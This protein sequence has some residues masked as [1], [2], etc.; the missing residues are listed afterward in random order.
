[1]EKGLI[2]FKVE[3]IL[4]YDVTASYSVVASSPREAAERATHLAVRPRRTG[5]FFVR[6]T[7]VSSGSVC[8]FSFSGL[9][10]W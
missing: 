8:E 5:Y 6:V 2:D 10:G 9:A 3:E 4:G 1:M 7:D